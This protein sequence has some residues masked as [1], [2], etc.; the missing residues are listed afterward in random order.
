MTSR[1]IVAAAFAA[2]LVAS[3]MAAADDLASQF[4]LPTDP[5]RIVPYNTS[6]FDG[7]TCRIAGD[8][9]VCTAIF[10]TRQQPV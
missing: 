7:G 4:L 10:L 3:S 1:V 2:V 9:G 5:E 6:F 8:V